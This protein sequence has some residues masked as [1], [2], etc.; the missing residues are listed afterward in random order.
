ML[1]RILDAAVSKS[2]YMAQ[3]DLIKF[4]NIVR[5]F[6]FVAVVVIMVLPKCSPISYESGMFYK[7]F[8]YSIKLLNLVHKLEFVKF[9]KASDSKCFVPVN[10][11]LQFM[12]M[13]RGEVFDAEYKRGSD[14]GSKR[15]FFV[16]FI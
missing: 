2:V 5:V 8:V 13:V 4:L 7:V 12:R 15:R 9:L 6:L 10:E 16:V 11:S 14:R 1:H 3:K